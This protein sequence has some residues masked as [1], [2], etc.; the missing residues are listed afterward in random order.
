MAGHLFRSSEA[1]IAK[2]HVEKLQSIQGYNIRPDMQK[3]IF[4][5]LLVR[6]LETT[7]FFEKLL[8]LQLDTILTI[9]Y[10]SW[11]Y[12]FFGLYPWSKFAN[13]IDM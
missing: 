8:T 12:L 2:H 9:V 6:K 5:G 1:C 4:R 11:D 7:G 13:E 3:N 10:H